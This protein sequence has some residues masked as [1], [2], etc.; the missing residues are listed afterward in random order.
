M[1]KQGDSVKFSVELK[2]K[3][4]KLF[5][6]IAPITVTIEDPAFR[7]AEPTGSYAVEN[8]K[9]TVILDLAKNDRIGTWKITAKENMTGT[10][11]TTYF[12]VQ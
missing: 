5:D 1:A 2:T 12:K 11:K 9:K 3:T 7:P 8:G 4:G 6:G 10:E